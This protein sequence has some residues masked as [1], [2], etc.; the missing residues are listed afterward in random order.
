MLDVQKAFDSVNHQHLCE[1]I[2]L[3]GIEPDWFI[4]Y[5]ENR[6]QI[7]LAN[8]VSSSE[9][10]IKCGVPQG[11]ILGPWCYLIYCNDLPV[12][13]KTSTVILYA[14]DTILL[15]SDRSLDKVREILLEDMSSCFHWLTDNKLA[16]HKGKT[17]MLVFSS[18]RK[19]HNTRNFKIDHDGHTISPSKVVK[20]LGLP[21]NC[22]LSGEEIVTAIVSK[23]TTRLKFLYRYRDHLTFMPRKILA[24]ALILSHF[25][26]SIRAWY[27]S[28]SK[29]HRTALQVAQNKVVRF[30][31]DLGPRS[32]IGQNE[33]DRVGLLC[34][35][36]RARQLI[37]HTMFDVHRGTAPSYLCNTFKHNRNRYSTRSGDNNFIVPRYTS[38]A[39]KNFNKI[40]AT[41]WNDLHNNVKV[42]SS[43]STFKK[44]VKSFLKTQAHSRANSD[45]LFY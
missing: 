11:S 25:D 33:L 28:L 29:K 45:F 31:L 26:Y 8:G 43:K 34:V 19:R 20:Y 18:N 42:L 37:L 22:L 17:E 40:G 38:L 21:L 16:M 39:T 35:K 30:V 14:D 36:D 32:H 9:Q 6:K 1:K 23:V 3:A 15:A 13:V 41:E 27:M 12:S 5:L 44:A 10:I 4:S 24:Q 2:K 7:V